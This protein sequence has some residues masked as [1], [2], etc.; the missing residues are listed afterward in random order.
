MSPATTRFTCKYANMVEVV[1][2]LESEADEFVNENFSNLKQKMFWAARH[3]AKRNN[4]EFTISEVDIV[5]PKR[6]PVFGMI[7][8]NGT[9]GNPSSPSLDRMDPSKG[10]TRENI[11]VISWRANSLKSNATPLEIRLLN[12]DMIRLVEMGNLSS[13]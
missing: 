12:N 7:L 11:R 13:E 8:K 4:L 3:R 5:I 10:Y 2:A 1:E 6:C 9:Y